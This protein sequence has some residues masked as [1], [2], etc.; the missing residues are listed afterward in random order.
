MNDP[1]VSWPPADFAAPCASDEWAVPT[2][3]PGR[4]L[5]PVPAPSQESEQFDEAG[6][7]VA[8]VLR[9][10]HA[11]AGDIV[12]EARMEAERVL[13]DAGD[14]ARRLRETAAVETRDELRRLAEESDT[15]ARERHELTRAEVREAFTELA[16]GA[17]REI[18]D[19][20]QTIEDEQRQLQAVLSEA[21]SGFASSFAED[22]PT[23]AEGS[24]V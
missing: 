7:E 1:A 14:D 4:E 3:S 8:A 5:A 19:A 16:A 20:L 9:A 2:S 15:E 24:Q 18:R 23:Q 10:A 12:K 17:I 13:I 22:D 21:G 6:R 11:S